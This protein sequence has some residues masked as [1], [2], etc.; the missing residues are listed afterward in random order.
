MCKENKLHKK[1]I[2]PKDLGENHDKEHAVWNR[3]S[4]LQALGLTSVGSI[5]LGKLPVSA[6]NQTPLSAALTT[7]DNDRVLV[8][9]RL[10]GGN[11]GLNTVIPQYD[12]DT[13]ANLR[14]NI[15]I[16]S[17]N[18]FA[19][20]SDFRMPNYMQD[21]QPL[22][23]DGKMKIAHG[24]GYPDQ[25]LSH[26]SSADIWS[27]TVDDDRTSLRTG[28]LGRYF[29]DLYPD[30]LLNPPTIPPAIQIGS[31]SN[32]LFNGEDTGYAFSVA[33]PNQLEEIAQNGTAYNVQNLS[34]CTYGN[35]LGWIRSIV[36]TTYTYAGVIHEAYNNAANNAGYNESNISKQLAIVA[37]LIKG[38]LGTKIYMVTLD[39]FDTHAEQPTAHQQ[40]MHDLT[41]AVSNFYE[42]LND[43]GVGKNVLAMTISEF[44]RRPEENGSNGTDHGS[45]STMMLFGEG[46]EGNGFIGTHPDLSNLDQDENLNFTTDFRSIYATI[47]EDWLCIDSDV[48]DASL[49]ANYNR[50]DVGVVC[51]SNSNPDNSITDFS[52]RAIYRDN[53]VFVDFD[54]P[55]ASH[56]TI[57]VINILGQKTG[58]IYNERVLAGNYQVDLNPKNKRYSVGQYFYQ[59]AV[60]GKLHSKAFVFVK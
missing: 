57:E 24:I 40:L 35:Q 6:A 51:N 11:D 5:M 26:F 33:N 25:N 41:N 60:N 29:E 16:E 10:K 30:Y 38:N 27:N 53:T 36:N 23:N 28:V 18:S 14:P 13:Y 50:S 19:L 34:E 2:N 20:S 4:F 39:G 43:I 56:V 52:H 49:L 15:K 59:I 31:L 3:R 1:Y 45:A 22:W 9:I 7:S 58:I 47:L 12:F 42:D 17:N 54:I 8:I 32:L 37:R 48:V 55:N 44:G 46:L 21:L